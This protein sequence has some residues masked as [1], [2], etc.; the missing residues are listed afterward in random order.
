MLE[1]AFVR[2]A[3]EGIVLGDQPSP[4]E[5][6][7]NQVVVTPAEIRQEFERNPEAWKQEKSLVWTTLQFFDD[8]SG[9]GL[10]RARA[11]AE[12]LRSGTLDTAG[13]A[14]QADSSKQDGGDPARKGLREDLR[15]W[16]AEASPGSVGEVEAI[17]GLG[18]QFLVLLERKEAR[19]I[20]FAEAQTEIARALRD[21]KR[22]SLMNDEMSAVIRSSYLWY[23]EELADLMRQVPGVEAE[24]IG[25]TEF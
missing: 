14:A 17:P 6:Y 20:G 21:R 15:Q 11:V 2:W 22:A 9:P 7:R 8:L 16:L 10:Q 1:G 25:E 5:G 19:E 23:A 24:N 18:A 13:A 12:E 4:L 3:W